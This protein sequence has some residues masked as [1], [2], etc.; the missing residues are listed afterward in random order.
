MIPY[1][2]K[3]GK[4]LPLRGGHECAVNIVHTAV[5]TAV[6]EPII[7]VNKNKRGKYPASDERRAYMRE[8]MR[9]RRGIQIARSP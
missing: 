2:Q 8:Y 3:C 7:A 5:N 6:N 1:C 9:K 4:Q